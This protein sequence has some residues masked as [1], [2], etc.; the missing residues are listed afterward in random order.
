MYN[1][2]LQFA[3]DLTKKI[4]ERAESGEIRDLDLMAEAVLSDC[5]ETSILVMS[6]LI[7]EMN[8]RI[9]GDNQYRK[10]LGLIIKEK[11]RPRSL[12]TVLGQID[13]SRDYFYDKQDGHCTC[14]LDQMLGI[15][16]YER[17][18]A[19]VGAALVTEAA[20]TSYAR[21]SEIVTNGIVSRQTVHNQ[22]LKVNVPEVRPKEEK[23]EVKELHIYADED[24]AH[25]QKPGKKK[26]KKCQVIP[27]V[28][29]TEGMYQES[30][31][32]NRTINPMHFADEG[33][34]TKRLWKAV[35]G[36]IEKAY[37]LE[38]IETV[39]IHGDG[40]PWIKNGLEDIA[41]TAHVIDGYHFMRDLRSICR[42]LPRRNIRV[43]LLWA[44]E[45]DDRERAHRYIQELLGETLSEK[46]L[47][48]IK[49]FAGRLFRFWEEIRRRL[50]EA[51]PGS[52]TEGQVS[53]VL[54]ERFS[55][56]PLGWSQKPLGKLVGVRVFWK[57][58]GKL[59]K[60]DFRKDTVQTERYSA[61]ADR[62]VEE[63]LKGAADFSLFEPEDPIF[64]TASGTQQLI[65]GLGRTRNTLF[66]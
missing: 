51:I 32:R 39:Y 57:N 16:K 49:D 59:T 23:R 65:R 37:D 27:L 46:D 13:F 54:S 45:N 55:R 10:E 17:I 36:Y 4:C 61:Y 43:T 25:M 11:D 24:H 33:F 19:A 44:L 3:I 8:E 20:K 40:G 29:V 26:G 56:D 12:L 6:E 62:L 9:R 50:T 14:V 63:H 48:R 18:G 58:G 64:D 42:I 52:C 66:Q 7:R 31:R 21:A 60:D 1:S 5:K 28:T 53:H 38:R 30:K 15:A 22:I 41:Q 35:E 34:N 2:I 47:K